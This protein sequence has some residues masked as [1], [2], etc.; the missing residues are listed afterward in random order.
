MVGV[1]VGNGSLT[2]P[3]A[4]F[5]P[6]QVKSTKKTRKNTLNLISNL[7]VYLA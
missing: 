7:L 3:N 4:K 5:E 2:N 6:R 1:F